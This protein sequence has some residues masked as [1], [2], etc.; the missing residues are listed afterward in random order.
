M[1]TH[2]QRN[3]T[4]GMESER[5]QSSLPLML[6]E[7]SWNDTQ[8]SIRTIYLVIKSHRPAYAWT[9]AKKWFASISPFCSS[10]SCSEADVTVVCNSVIFFLKA[11]RSSKA[12]SSSSLDSA[13]AT[14]VVGLLRFFGL[15]FSTSLVRA[16]V[17]RA[18]LSGCFLHSHKY[19]EWNARANAG[20]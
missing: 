17:H 2:F 14:G 20:M 11:D 19:A 1:N 5:M 4:S 6:P 8:K 18:T 9:E 15:Y 12:F 3:T 13:S 16:S 7:T 10:S